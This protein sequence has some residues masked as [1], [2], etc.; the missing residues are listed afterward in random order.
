MAQTIKHR[1]T[2]K[3]IKGDIV[4]VLVVQASACST[5]TAKQLCHS[6]ESKE[7]IVDVVCMQPHTIH[8]GDEVQVVAS[9]SSGLKA[10]FWAYVLPLIL[11]MGSVLLAVSV[12]G[13]EPAGAL[14]ALA[15][16]AAYYLVLY[17]CRAQISRKLS[18]TI[19]Q[20]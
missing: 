2:V 13:S 10:V 14:C 12:T 1:G 9:L 4:S 11:L 3:S 16:L 19:Q 17:L 6:A 15:V 20:L 8:I 18:F 7:K 5:C